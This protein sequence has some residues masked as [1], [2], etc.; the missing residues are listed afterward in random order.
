MMKAK[1]GRFPFDMHQAIFE[2]KELKRKARNRKLS[3]LVISEIGGLRNILFT[4]LLIKILTNE[5]FN[6]II[7]SLK[8]SLTIIPY[9]TY[10][11]LPHL[12]LAIQ[13]EMV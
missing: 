7:E 11:I 10:E 2:A 9:K 1:N 5:E 8:L 13:K 6:N 12:D 3:V 4:Y